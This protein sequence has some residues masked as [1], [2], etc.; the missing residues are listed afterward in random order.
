MR[1]PNGGG[2]RLA[3]QIIGDE[4][5]LVVLSPRSIARIMGTLRSGILPQ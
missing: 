5:P 3:S 2:D 1:L 4:R